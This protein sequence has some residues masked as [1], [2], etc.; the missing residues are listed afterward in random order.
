ML[1]VSPPLEEAGGN[2][3]K[4]ESAPDGSSS[5]R[6]LNSSRYQDNNQNDIDIPSY[7]GSVGPVGDLESIGLFGH[8]KVKANKKERRPND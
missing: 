6:I 7:H 1:S 3:G 4:Y 2:S 5:G 8:L